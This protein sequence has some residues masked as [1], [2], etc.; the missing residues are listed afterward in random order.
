MHL[1]LYSPDE[2]LEAA[3]MVRLGAT[4]IRKNEDPDDTFVVL[5]DPEGNEFCV[6]RLDQPAGSA[7]PP[8]G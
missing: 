6:C 4:R 7:A 2:E 3:R 8:E 5:T 1:D